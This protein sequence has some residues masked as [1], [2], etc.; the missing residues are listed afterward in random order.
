MNGKTSKCFRSG[1]IDI[2]K[3]AVKCGLSGMEIKLLV[4]QLPHLIGDQK[5]G[6]CSLMSAASYKKFVYAYNAAIHVFV[7]M[8]LEKWDGNIFQEWYIAITKFY[9]AWNS[10]YYY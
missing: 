10:Y 6:G 9:H 2:E 4:Q 7:L 3:K 5:E 1:F 8:D